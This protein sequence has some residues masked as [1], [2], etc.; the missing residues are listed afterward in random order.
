MNI[1]YLIVSEWPHTAAIISTSASNIISIMINGNAYLLPCHG[2]T[3][4]L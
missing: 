4:L 2:M 1:Q 3:L